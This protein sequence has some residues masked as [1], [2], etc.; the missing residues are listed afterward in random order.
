VTAG[1][2]PL[3]IFSLTDETEYAR[4]SAAMLEVLCQP[5]FRNMST[6]T[7]LTALYSMPISRAY[8]EKE[9]THAEDRVVA[10]TEV[11][12]HIA[13]KL[14]KDDINQARLLQDAQNGVFQLLTEALSDSYP[15][16]IWGYKPA[17]RIY[18]Q[19]EQ[20]Q[21]NKGGKYGVTLHGAR[22]Q[23]CLS[24]EDGSVTKY[25]YLSREG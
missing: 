10:S 8:M 14:G 18:E 23:R 4:I 11:A 3:T 1:F 17:F 19:K 22:L 5:T 16:V 15:Q 25:M 9:L 20:A 24:S 7:E 12:L 2:H 21:P 13:R 6:Y